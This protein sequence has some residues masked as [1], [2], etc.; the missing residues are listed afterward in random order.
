[1]RIERWEPERDGPLSEPAFRRKLRKLGFGAT[2]YVYP[3]GTVFEEHSH[4]VDKMDAV[5]SG[6]FRIEMTGRSIV[7]DPGD[8]LFVPR[9]TPHRAAVVGNEPV[10]SLDGIR[11]E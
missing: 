5:I 8:A 3:P 1:M 9:G 6:R 7:L 4:D 11:E 10:V 2:R